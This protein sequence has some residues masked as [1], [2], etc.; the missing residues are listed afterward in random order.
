MGAVLTCDDVCADR[1]AA[2]PCAAYVWS[3]LAVCTASSAFCVLV[4]AHSEPTDSGR[5][6]RRHQVRVPR[7]L[8]RLMGTFSSGTGNG[9]RNR[10]RRSGSETKRAKQNVRRP[11]PRQRLPSI[12]S[13]KN[14][15]PKKSDRS[16]KT[17]TSFFVVP[18]N[19]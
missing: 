5:R 1:V 9:T 18:P 3:C 19:G 2:A 11:S 4:D 7:L 15:P 14:T 6:T 16:G 8:P 13:T 10:Q 12:N 17:S